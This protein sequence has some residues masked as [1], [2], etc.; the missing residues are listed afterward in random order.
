MLAVT[1]GILVLDPTAAQI[2]LIELVVPDFDVDQDEAAGIRQRIFAIE[3]AD[4]VRL[5]EVIVNVMS[6]ER[7]PAARGSRRRRRAARRRQP[8]LATTTDDDMKIIPAA[9]SLIVTAPEDKMAE[10]AGLISQVD[11]SWAEETDIR[12][13]PLPPGVNVRKATQ[14]L[15]QLL[16]GITVSGEQRGRS[17]SRRRRAAPR[18]SDRAVLVPQVS[19][20]T[21]V[22]SAP[23]REFERIE[24]TIDLVSAEKPGL[25]LVYDVIDVEQERAAEIKELIRPFLQSRLAE[26]IEAGK[27]QLPDGTTRTKSRRGKDFFTIQADPQGD[28]LIITA[29][30]LLMTEARAFVAALDRPAGDDDEQVVRTVTLEKADPQK[31]CEIIR[32]MLAGRNPRPAPGQR[33]KGSRGRTQVRR[34]QASGG[35]SDV[36]VEPA[37]GMRALVLMGGVGDIDTVE[38]W[39]KHLDRS[40]VRSK[41]TVKVYNLDGADMETVVDTVMHVVDTG[42]AM[43]RPAQSRSDD[44]TLAGLDMEITRQGKDVYING[45]T[46]TGVMLVGATPAKL[47]MV[48]RVVGTFVGDGHSAPF[49][50]S[51]RGTLPCM[52]YELHYVDASDG[53]YVLEHILDVLWPFE[54][55]PQVDFVPLTNILVV[56]GDPEHFELVEELIV[57]YVDK[58]GTAPGTVR[59]VESTVGTGMTARDA[60]MLLE[61]ELER[62]GWD[63]EVEPVGSTREAPAAE[64]TEP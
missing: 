9:E 61:C 7:G 29:P 5:R 39:I 16:P 49:S 2:E 60:A 43:R 15:S 11:L 56:K 50:N 55:I 30:H 52:T 17:R 62:M 10:I 23:T 44:S 64:A 4:P 35:L 45:D 58:A 33:A 40:A 54:N 28:R 13:Y 57:K 19:S 46:L 3:H 37:P 24:E 21:I 20:H 27:I 6:P 32:S 38:G 63:V 59:S 53:A 14:T 31:T 22:V 51:G 42:G 41:R 8:P 47:R 18:D 34:P 48:D 12:V 25:R 26:L 36:V 1:D